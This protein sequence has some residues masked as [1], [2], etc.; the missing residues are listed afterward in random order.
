MSSALPG[1][2][3]FGD[4][5]DVSAAIGATAARQVTSKAVTL[6]AANVRGY[7]LAAQRMTPA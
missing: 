7:L 3:G 5:A 1:D 4:V 2:G 6:V